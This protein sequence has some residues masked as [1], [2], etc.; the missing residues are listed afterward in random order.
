M[1]HK[2][3]IYRENSEAEGVNNNLSQRWISLDIYFSNSN[4]HR[5]SNSDKKRFLKSFLRRFERDE[6]RFKGEIQKKERVIVNALGYYKIDQAVFDGVMEIPKNLRGKRS[7]SD[8][9]LVRG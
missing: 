9:V 3:S 5:L 7:S 6:I 1:R 2:V 4:F 8:E